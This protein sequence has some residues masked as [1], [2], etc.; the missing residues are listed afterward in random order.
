VSLCIIIIIII[1]YYI[2]LVMLHK[3]LDKNER[4]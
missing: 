4:Y 1:Y 3:S 2:H